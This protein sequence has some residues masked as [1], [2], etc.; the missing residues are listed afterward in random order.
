MKGRIIGREGRN[1]RSFESVSGCDVVIDESPD[2]VVISSFNPVRREIGR[3]AMEKLLAD[4][5]IHPSRIEEVVSRTR[6]EIDRVIKRKGEEA[7]LE[8]EI[9]GLHPKLIVTLGRLHFVSSFGQNA[10]RHSVEVAHLAGLLA[11]EIGLKRKQAV[12]AGLLHDIGKAMD[13]EVDG[14]TSSVG[15]SLCRKHGE[16]KTIVS[17]ASVSTPASSVRRSII[18]SRRQTL[19]PRTVLVPSESLS[20]RTSNDLD[21][22]T[23]FGVRRRRKS[24]RNQGR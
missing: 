10:L 17:A 15:A 23:D 19:Y 4:G 14:D 6:K 1:I 20:Q 5:R 24:L 12:R 16:A 22:T 21:S 2:T 3:L 8:L 9:T 11:D 7:A 18:L 13:H